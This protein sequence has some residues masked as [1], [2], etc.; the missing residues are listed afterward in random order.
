[1]D[2]KPLY[3][4][5]VEFIVRAGDPEQALEHLKQA[6]RPVAGPE[7]SAEQVAVWAFSEPVDHS[8]RL[9]RKD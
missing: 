9:Q 7:A 5:A 4:I 2:P 1:M 3:R 8:D 6:L